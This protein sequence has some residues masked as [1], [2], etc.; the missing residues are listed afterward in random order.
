M[1]GDFTAHTASI[2]NATCDVNRIAYDLAP[3]F[4]V[5][6]RGPYQTCLEPQLETL[7]ALQKL[8]EWPDRLLENLKENNVDV[9]YG[10]TLQ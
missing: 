4:S 9:P 1:P 2:H 10:L 3:I 8:A 7:D 5:E 6:M